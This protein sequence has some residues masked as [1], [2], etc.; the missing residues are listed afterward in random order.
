METL[1]AQRDSFGKEL[2]PAVYAVREQKIQ[3][4]MATG[5]D[6]WSSENIADGRQEWSQ[7]TDNSGKDHTKN[8]GYEANSKAQEGTPS[9][10]ALSLSDLETRLLDIE[11]QLDYWKGVRDTARQNVT[12][13]EARIKAAKEVEVAT[14]F[15]KGSSSRHDREQALRTVE[16]VTA[17]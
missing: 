4:L 7:R 5:R 6:R 14:A 9:L 8:P 2:T 3:E 17:S 15:A 11:E 1:E 12:E 10:G 13:C 16:R